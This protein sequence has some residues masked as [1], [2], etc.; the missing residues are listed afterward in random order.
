[1]L[2]GPTAF[3]SL[4]IIDLSNYFNLYIT[5]VENLILIFYR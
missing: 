2:S 3:G 1:M 4:I 5:K